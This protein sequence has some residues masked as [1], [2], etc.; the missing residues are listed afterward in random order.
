MK[1]SD[2]VGNSGLSIYAEIA[3]VIFVLAFLAILVWLFR[4]GAKER[5]GRDARIPLDDETP[6]ERRT[7][8]KDD[9]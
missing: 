4:P 9:A 6:V 7:P 1:L 2:V 3:L 8:R 5:F